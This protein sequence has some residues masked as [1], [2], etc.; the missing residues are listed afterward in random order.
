MSGFSSQSV[1]LFGWESCSVLFLYIS[2]DI[3]KGL[4]KPVWLQ[5]LILI[6][7]PYG[8]LFFLSTP[9]W[10]PL[11]GSYHLL[12]AMGML[13]VFAASSAA[14]LMTLPVGVHNLLGFTAYLIA[15]GCMT[16]YFFQSAF[17]STALNHLFLAVIWV[18]LPIVIYAGPTRFFQR[19][20]FHSTQAVIQKPSSSERHL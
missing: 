4:S 15:V 18:V 19:R 10:L 20:L 3:V 16:V 5:D 8:Y 9:F 2:L 14:Y 11:R 7:T 6:G 12:F 17:S 13:M 1:P